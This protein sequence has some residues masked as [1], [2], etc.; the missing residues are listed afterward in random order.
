LRI[1]VTIKPLIINLL[2]LIGLGFYSE[3]SFCQERI[4]SGN[5]Q[6]AL[7]KEPIGF[8]SVY[9]KKGGAG[10]ITDS[11]GSFKFNFENTQNDTLVI[12]YI[13]Y[14][15][16]FIP[17]DS[18]RISEPLF[19]NLERSSKNDEVVVKLKINKGLFLWKKIMS[20]K[21][22]FDRSKKQNYGYEAYN[23]IEIDIKNL[24]SGFVKVR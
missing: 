8:A 13:G 22:Y 20:K 1:C 16:V 3:N 5:I 24:N 23:K 6:D 21:K 15:N 9:L 18:F 19:I 12:S 10:K 7:T 2:L 11:S 17:L 4:L 14:K